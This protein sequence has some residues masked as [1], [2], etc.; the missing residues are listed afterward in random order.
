[1][2]PIVRHNDENVR[3]RTHVDDFLSGRIIVHLKCESRVIFE[4]L[5]I[6][7]SFI[8]IVW[9]LFQNGENVSRGKNVSTGH[10]RVTTPNEDHY[11]VVTA[12]RTRQ[13]TA[14]DLSRQLSVAPFQDKPCT[15]VWDI[16]AYM[17]AGRS[18]VFLLMT[19]HCRLRLAC[20]R[21]YATR[22]HLHSVFV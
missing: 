12:K 10:S 1:M 3:N 13:N 18:D 22:R 20:S 8:V 9:K 17:L 19:T 2:I 11:L 6:V 5:K 7:Q 4:E 21:K 14:S 15:D 16:L